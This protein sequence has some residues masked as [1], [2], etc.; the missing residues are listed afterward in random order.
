MIGSALIRGE[1]APWV[2]S[3]DSLCNEKCIR[4]STLKRTCA[5]PDTKPRPVGRPVRCDGNVKDTKTTTKRCKG[6]FCAVKVYAGKQT[7]TIGIGIIVM[8]VVGAVSLVAVPGGWYLYKRRRNAKAD[9][10]RKLNTTANAKEGDPE[11]Y[12]NK[13][14]S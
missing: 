8:V 4:E 10:L 13:A 11:G 6:D 7:G 1:W 14:F 12:D 9:D 3:K 2:I 5:D